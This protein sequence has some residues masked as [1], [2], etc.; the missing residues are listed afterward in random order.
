MRGMKLI[1]SAAS[2]IL[3]SILPVRFYRIQR[4]RHYVSCHVRGDNTL[5]S[6]SIPECKLISGSRGT[7]RYEHVD[8]YRVDR[9]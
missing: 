2:T 4:A 6:W 9:G 7:A 5:L 8:R 1:T 3:A